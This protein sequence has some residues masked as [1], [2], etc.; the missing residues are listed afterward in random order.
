MAS[1]A[2]YMPDFMSGGVQRQQLR[3]APSLIAAGHDLTFVVHRADGALVDKV[4]AEA[5]VVVLGVKR[6]V[7][8]IRPL[9]RYIK[10]ARPDI[11]VANMG[12]PNLVALA[13][14]KL[15]GKATRV[16]ACHHSHLSNQSKAEGEWQHKILPFLIRRFL[17][18]ADAI[19]AVSQGVADDLARVADVPRERIDVIYNPAVPDDVATLAAQPAGHP[20]LGQPEPVVIAIGRLVPLKEFGML[21]AA[22]AGLP[23]ARLVIMGEGPMLD[24]L[25]EEAERVGMSDRVDF[26][27][28]QANPYAFL[29]RARLFVLS[30]KY[31]GFGNVIA[32]ALACGTPVVSTDCE[33]G[34]SEI[35]D[36]GRFGTLVPVGDQAA[37]TAAMSAALAGPHD[38]A[39]LIARGMEFS[40]SRAAAAYLALFDRVLAR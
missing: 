33:S 39:A 38:R 9:A 10:S 34:P 1:I 8:A 13:A 18:Y 25:K 32:E 35:L 2:I 6:T 5:K 36:G 28:F 14:N 30:S 12:H 20:W 37:M 7:S 3:L 11:V 4:P 16:V 23:D 31:E 17:R 15:A 22:T 29:S 24:P 21:I 26:A 27:G 19:V 40:V